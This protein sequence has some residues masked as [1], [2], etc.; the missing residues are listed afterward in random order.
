MPAHVD[1]KMTNRE[2]IQPV[3]LHHETYQSDFDLKCKKFVKNEAAG[4]F[5]PTV[6][7]YEMERNYDHPSLSGI[8]PGDPFRAVP[9]QSV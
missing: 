8:W 3:K 4:T 9:L 6:F 7:I 5:Q 2:I 1:T